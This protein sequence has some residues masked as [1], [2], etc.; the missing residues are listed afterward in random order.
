LKINWCAGNESYDQNYWI[1]DASKRDKLV[2]S[3][4]RMK[5][6]ILGKSILVPPKKMMVASYVIVLNVNKTMGA[7]QTRENMYVMRH[8]NILVWVCC[9]VT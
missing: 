4:R 3:N 9:F 2:D 7:Y 5:Y 1:D 6:D 8:Y